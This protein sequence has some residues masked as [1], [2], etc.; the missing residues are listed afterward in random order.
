MASP[1]LVFFGN[2]RIA[3]GVTTSVPTLRALVAAGY[4]IAAVVVAQN[5]AAKSRQARPLEIAA[6]AAEHNIPV[7][8]PAKLADA[9]DEIAALEADAAVLVAYGK[10]VPEDVIKAFPRGIINIHPSLLPKHRGSA[11]IE[12]AIMA[13]DDQ[14]GVSL[15]QLAKEMD[16]GPVYAQQV[17]PLRGDET[18]QYLADQLL[19]IGKNLLLTHLPNILDGSLKTTAQDDKQASYDNQLQKAGSE[20]DFTQPAAQVARQIRAFDVWPRS[21]AKL[22]TTEVIITAAHVIDLNGTAGTLWLE[23][24][25]LGVHCAEGTLVIDSLIPPGKKEMAAAAFL[26]GYSL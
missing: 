22:G 19:E 5:Q 14:T 21:R 20:L 11:P 25:Q 17:L 24:N 18:K 12:G 23:S 13:G 7:L 16:A 8:S 2:E 9:K 6:V 3:T 26:A 1:R 4:D 10:L 15:M